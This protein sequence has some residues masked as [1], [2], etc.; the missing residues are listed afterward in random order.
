MAVKRYE[1]DA[2]KNISSVKRYSNGA[3]VNCSFVKKYINGAWVTVYPTEYYLIKDGVFNVDFSIIPLWKEQVL[4]DLIQDNVTVDSVNGYVNLKNTGYSDEGSLITTEAI[5][6][7]P[8]TQLNVEAEAQM[9]L[10]SATYENWARF[11]AFSSIP[12][13]VMTGS[14][15]K[16]SNELLTGGGF[17]S[18]TGTANSTTYYAANGTRSLADINTTG[19][20]FIDITSWNIGTEYSNLRIKNLW[21]S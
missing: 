3:W 8:Y 4:S 18:F 15:A 21:L 7:T 2:W 20:I 6:L 14:S 13:A 10:A 9:Y 16:Y 1:K 17:Y 12:E 5:D 19:H 11:G